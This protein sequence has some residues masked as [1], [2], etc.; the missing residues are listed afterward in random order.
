MQE[1]PPIDFSMF[2]TEPG[3]PRNYKHPSSGV[4]GVCWRKGHNKWQVQ[5][6]IDGNKTFLGNYTDLLEAKTVAATAMLGKKPMQSVK[7]AGTT[8]GVIGI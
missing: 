6:V 8:K 4:V 2:R 3:K 7:R 5:I 1:T